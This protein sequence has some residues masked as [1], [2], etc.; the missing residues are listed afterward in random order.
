LQRGHRCRELQAASCEA[1]NL[2]SK[3]ADRARDA[4]ILAGEAVNFAG[5]A[6]ITAREVANLA[7]E[8]LTKK[9]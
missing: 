5:D 1:A 6:S 3:A 8:E 7:R 9:T 4:V 2:T